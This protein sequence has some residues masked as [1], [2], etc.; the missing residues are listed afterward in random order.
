M[1]TR[2]CLTEKA[3]IEYIFKNLQKHLNAL[4]NFQNKTQ[5]CYLTPRRLPVGIVLHY[6][7]QQLIT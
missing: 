5:M 1:S 2:K 7:N 6:V 4:Y 3:N